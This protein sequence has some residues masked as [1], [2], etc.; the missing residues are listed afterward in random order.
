[1]MFTFD[2]RKKVIG[3][4][5][6]KENFYFFCPYL[7]MDTNNFSETLQ[8]VYNRHEEGLEVEAQSRFLIPD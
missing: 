7:K 8:Y 5:F 3:P 4:D 2:I 6:S 1:M